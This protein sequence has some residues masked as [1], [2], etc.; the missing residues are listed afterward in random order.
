MMLKFSMDRSLQKWRMRKRIIFTMV[1]MATI[2]VRR[3]MILE[4]LRSSSVFRIL[5]LDLLKEIRS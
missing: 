5:I 3:Y 1:A 2:A 4:Y